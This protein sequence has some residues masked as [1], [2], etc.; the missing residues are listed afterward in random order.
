MKWELLL[1]DDE[2]SI[3]DALAELLEDD[4]LTVMK[5][6]NGLEGLMLMREKHF[7]V[8]VSDIS[9]P[10]MDG[11][12]MLSHA[13]AEGI[14]TP[15]IFFSANGEVD[16]PARVRSLGAT[17]FVRKPYFE[18]LSVEINSVLVKNEI[19]SAH[20]SSTYTESECLQSL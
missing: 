11:L 17:G 2:P 19:L 7:D 9:M 5:A 14:F 3:L 4:E 1:I 15:L 20:F 16:L 13:R 12:T 6:C 18:K 8:V 10:L